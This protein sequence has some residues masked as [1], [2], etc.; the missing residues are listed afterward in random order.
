[1]VKFAVM[2]QK[3]DIV[4]HTTMRQHLSPQQVQFVRLLEM[5]GAE[6]EEAVRQELDENPALEAEDNDTDAL[7]DHDSEQGAFS[8]SAEQ[9]QAA[10]YGDE[11][12]MPAY[13]LNAASNRSRDDYYNAADNGQE[14]PSLMETLNAELDLVDAPARDVLIAR[15]LI[16]YLDDNGRMTRS[17][18]DIAADI[19]DATGA[20]VRR[21]DLLPALNIIKYQL[22]PPGLGAVD[23]RECLLIQLRRKEPKTLA[24][25]VAEDVIEHNFDLFTKKHFKRIEKALGVDKE[26]L[27]EALEVIRMLDPKPGSSVEDSASSR[28]AHITP[29]FIVTPVEGS[30]D[31]FSIQ[32]NQRLPELAVEQS[33]R[34][35]STDRNA[36]MFIRSKRDQANTFIS[37]IR[38]RSETLMAVMEAIVRIQRRFFETEDMASLRPMILSDISE[39]TGL[40]KSVISRATSNKYVATQAAVYPLKMFFND[41]PTDDADTSASEIISKMQQLIDGEDKSHP[42][43]D[44]AIS[45]ALNQQGYALARRTVAKYREKMNI[46]VARLRKEY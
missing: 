28:I 42:L 37:L 9:I 35:N 18:A 23:L 39:M 22:D 12:D 1:M 27:D 41:T 14:A 20:E 3:A 30:P 46:P 43:S 7:A 45:E 10:D 17:L 29:D 33:F 44:Q 15:Y 40:D 8:E 34:I 5:N 4:Q 11:D 2:K 21:A 19:S 25:R 16:G 38:R 31:R 36:Q 6:I 26:T 24:I 32:L 13:L